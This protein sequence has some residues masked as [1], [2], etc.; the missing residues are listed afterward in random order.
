LTVNWLLLGLL[1]ITALGGVLIGLVVAPRGPRPERKTFFV[2]RS[3][4]EP[5][6]LEPLFEARS[7]KSAQQW[8]VEHRED[9]GAENNTLYVYDSSYVR[10]YNARAMTTTKF[11]DT[12]EALGRAWEQLQEANGI[13]EALRGELQKRPPVLDMGRDPALTVDAQ[14]QVIHDTAE[15]ILDEIRRLA[16]SPPEGIPHLVRAATWPEPGS[17]MAQFTPTEE[18]ALDAAASASQALPKPPAGAPSVTLMKPTSKPN[19]QTVVID[20]GTGQRKP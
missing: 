4:F 8:K 12:I 16:A 1:G 11:W 2:V 15:L 9:F 20:M 7:I 17:V 5:Q 14:T 13:I 18:M 19:T 3:W 6:G 10:D